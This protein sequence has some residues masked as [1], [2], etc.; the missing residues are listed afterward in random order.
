GRLVPRFGESGTDPGGPSGPS[1]SDFGLARGEAV[2][3][4]AD[5]R[6]HGMFR[7]A[8]VAT[9]DRV[10]NGDVLVER[11]LCPASLRAGAKPIEPKLVIELVSEHRFEPVIA[12]EL[13]D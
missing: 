7:P 8:R 9:L 12:G 11:S 5:M 13:D 6:A 10:D 2:I 3:G 1:G 4:I